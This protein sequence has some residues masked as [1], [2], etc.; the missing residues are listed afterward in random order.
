MRENNT[1]FEC[2]KCADVLTTRNKYKQLGFGMVI[3]GIL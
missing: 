2:Q 1:F 3:Y